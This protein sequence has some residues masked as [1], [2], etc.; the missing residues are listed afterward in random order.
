MK[1]EV[2][3]KVLFEIIGLKLWKYSLWLM[4]YSFGIIYGIY[5]ICKPPSTSHFSSGIATEDMEIDGDDCDE[6]NF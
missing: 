6:N 5:A 1:K 2:Y 4:P 3:F